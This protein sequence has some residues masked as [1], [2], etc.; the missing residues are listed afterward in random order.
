MI[1][2]IFHSFGKVEAFLSAPKLRR[3]ELSNAFLLEFLVLPVEQLIS[4]K[5][6]DDETDFD[7][8]MFVDILPRCKQLV[9]LEISLPPE[10]FIGFSTRLSILLPTLRS[11]EVTCYNAADNILRCITT[12]L[13]ERLSIRYYY[14]RD[15]DG[16]V[17]DMTAFQQRSST[18]L[19][20]LVFYPSIT[21]NRGH[22]VTEKVIAILLQELTLNGYPNYHRTENK[23]CLPQ[24]ICVQG[25]D[26]FAVVVGW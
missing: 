9:S 14:N 23:G 5:V 4:L 22:K 24:W 20:S 19:L 17:V 18:A 13:L 6:N 15:L 2:Q 11:L 10:G 25:Y 12:P 7:P 8:V 3:V 16:L 1:R 26:P 21:A